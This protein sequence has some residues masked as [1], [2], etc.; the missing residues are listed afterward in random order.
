M[1]LM[2]RE[3]AG[4]LSKV[5]LSVVS[6]IRR[7]TVQYTHTD[8][9]GE[10]EKQT[11]APSLSL[12]LPLWSFVHNVCFWFAHNKKHV[13]EVLEKNSWIEYRNC[14]EWTIIYTTMIT[15]PY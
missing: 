8:R 12:S 7:L 2:H 5:F 4:A 13:D 1:E 14:S 6:L 11:T 15:S 9:D 3:K 10:R